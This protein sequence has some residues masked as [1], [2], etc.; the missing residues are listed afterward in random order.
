MARREDHYGELRS[1]LEKERLD[2]KVREFEASH[3]DID[4]TP[5][6]ENDKT[7]K[8]RQILHKKAYASYKAFHFLKNGVKR[9]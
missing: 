9:G 8:A 6:Y 1:P 5:I 4:L 3:P 2:R 7:E